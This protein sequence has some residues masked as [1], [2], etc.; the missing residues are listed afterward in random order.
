MPSIKQTL[1]KKSKTVPVKNSGARLFENLR[2]MVGR[3]PRLL[4]ALEF[5]FGHAAGSLS[6]HDLRIQPMLASHRNT[7]SEK[8]FFL[9]KE[10]FGGSEDVSLVPLIRTI[11]DQ[12]LRAYAQ[13]SPYVSEQIGKA[14]ISPYGSMGLSV[15]RW[16][17]V[18]W[19]YIRDLDW[20]IFLPPQ[21]GHLSGFK[22]DLER[23]LTSELH[24]YGL[25][26]VLFGKD[27]RGLPQVQLREVGTPAT[28]GFHFF[29]IAMKPG[30]VRGNLHR[31]GGYSPHY[32]YF[33]EGSLDEHLQA[34]SMQWSDVIQQ[35]REDYVDMF[36]QL[37]FN[38][39]GENSAESGKLKTPGWYLHKAFKWYATLA[40]VR[41][42]PSLEED[43]MYQYEH[44][45]GSE[46]ELSYLARYR[47]YARMA[48]SALR[49]DDLDRD[50]A[51]VASIV[52][53]RARNP[54]DPLVGQQISAETSDLAVLEAVSAD[55]V[56][57]AR[58]LLVQNGVAL[59]NEVPDA[60][61]I[62]FADHLHAPTRARL[63]DGQAAVLIP[64]EWS[65]AF[66]DSYI[67]Q[68]MKR[69][70]EERSALAAK[71]IRQALAALLASVL[72]HA[73]LPF[74]SGEGR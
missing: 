62:R 45:Q 44:F 34:S 52:Y 38:I 35:Q 46:A 2:A 65:L 40:R 12:T 14:P 68:V 33:P 72:Y 24:K 13:A 73:L 69:A 49:L 32:A 61:R 18:D 63:E 64:A 53:A 29:L 25:Y 7:V 17:Y 54:G 57:A 50:L 9:P 67:Y 28:H 15:S 56:A 26:P 22:T 74:R 59:P 36:N 51:R 60:A 8:S 30:F 31:D 39:F 21:I 37:S 27:E 6:V 71:D 20:R 19:D 70:V 43:L 66:S 11:V 48:P 10:R 1:A 47:Y 5:L 41:G 4:R 16:G 23:A 58:K 55:F 3:S 42:L